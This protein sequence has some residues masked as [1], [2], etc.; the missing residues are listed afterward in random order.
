MEIVA[1]LFNDLA[2]MKE[3]VGLNRYKIEDLSGIIE[4][5]VSNLSKS[6]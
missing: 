3:I 4:N 6:A 5:A 2:D 1:L